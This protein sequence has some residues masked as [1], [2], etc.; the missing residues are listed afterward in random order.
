[1][2]IR[3][4]YLSDVLSASH[5][6]KLMSISF[7]QI[8]VFYSL[9]NYN[10]NNKLKTRQFN[11]FPGPDPTHLPTPTQFRYQLL[12]HHFHDKAATTVTF[13]LLLSFPTKI[14]IIYYETYVYLIFL[15]VS[16]SVSL[17]LY[18]QMI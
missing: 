16:S 5:R 15:I 7:D 11:D 18:N 1:M 3:P 12:L 2:L 9:C 17:I 4:Q 6:V 14:F 10:L 13:P 8:E